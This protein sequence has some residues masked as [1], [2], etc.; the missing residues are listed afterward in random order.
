[1]N[2]EN[3]LQS[4][5][6]KLAGFPQKARTH[7]KP[8]SKRVEQLREAYAIEEGKLAHIPQSSSGQIRLDAENEEGLESPLDYLPLP[9][10]KKGQK[11]DGVN[12]ARA[13]KRIERCFISVGRVLL[14]TTDKFY[15]ENC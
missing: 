7:K 11:R 5:R 13:G 4:L 15:Q 3:L 6:S 10:Q 2:Q 8:G 14:D 12:M 1:M 9:R